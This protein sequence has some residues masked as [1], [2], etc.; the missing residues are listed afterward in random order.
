MGRGRM[1]LGR[2]VRRAKTPMGVLG[3]L[4]AAVVAGVFATHKFQQSTQGVPKEGVISRV[5]DGDTLHV[6]AGGTEHTLRLIGVDTPEVHPSDKLTR[7]AHRTKQDEK[8]I[9]G[10]GRKA[11]DFTKRLCEGKSCRLEYDPANVTSRH[12]DKYDRLLAFVYVAGEGGQEVLVN[13][14]IIRQGYG[15]AMTSYAFDASR[16]D[17]FRRLEREA[18][19]KKRGL[20][21]KW[22]P[23]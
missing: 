17:E 10:L 6:L 20:W 23:E 15:Q 11:W 19:A 1:S 9:V 12:R 2:A 14:E 7:D 8:T 3:A 5:V 13:A 4:V 16:Q 18:R 22:R 21:D